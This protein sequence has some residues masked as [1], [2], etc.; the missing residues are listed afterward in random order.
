MKSPTHNVSRLALSLVV[1]GAF[2]WVYA[3]NLTPPPGRITPTMKTLV[4][5][6]PRR[7]IETLGGDDTA[8]YVLTEP[9]SYYLTGNLT[10]QAAK[11]G[12]K[13]AASDVMLDL[14]GF[15]L[16]GVEGSLSGIVRGQ[17]GGNRVV[18]RNGVVRN[19]GE[20]GVNS[21]TAT[22]WRI[23]DVGA[24][25]N[26][27]VGIFASTSSIRDCAAFGNAGPG[28]VLFD[29][30]VENCTATGNGGGGI[31]AGGAVVRGCSARENADGIVG[32]VVVHCVAASNEGTGI[33]GT[34]VSQCTSSN[35]GIGIRASGFA[36]IQNNNCINNEV[37][38][39]VGGF[40]NRVEGNHVQS[41]G[42]GI[43]V[44]GSR[45]MILRNSVWGTANG[46][47]SIADG[48]TFGP[49]VNASGDLSAIENADHP[50]ANF[51]Y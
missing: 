17:G 30:T 1:L 25:E 23:V 11:H 32:G 46:N 50:W 29:G 33:E 49:V 47:F 24:H 39:Q 48:N 6:E 51:V 16:D 22:E 43:E 42:A 31:R 19:W 37:G 5:V 7:A 3:G 27:G 13:I 8:L 44:Q 38:I 18:I 21:L 35:N 12:I 4:E 20:Y 34:L 2:V 14:A 36:S 40:A 41:G 15:T 9:G 10:G 28:I 45:N 26:Q